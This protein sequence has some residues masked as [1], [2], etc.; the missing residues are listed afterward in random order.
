MKSSSSVGPRRPAF[1]EFWLS[2][3]STPWLVVS[4]RAPESTRAAS[5]EPVLVSSPDTTGPE[6]TFADTLVSL[7]VLPVTAPVAGN[8]DGP[9]AGACPACS[10]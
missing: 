5:S 8:A 2:A 1:S 10:P 6:P 7:S 3:T 4:A 9:S